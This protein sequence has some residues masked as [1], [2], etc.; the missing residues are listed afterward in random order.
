M[1]RRRSWRPRWLSVPGLTGFLLALLLVGA[2]PGSASEPPLARLLSPAMGDELAVGSM[3]TVEW[4]PAAGLAAMERAEEWEAF[5]SVDGG[6]TYP[7]R[8]TPHLD[9][10]IRR[11]SFRVPDLPSRQARLLLRFGDERREEVDCETR[12][13]FAIHRPPGYVPL[14]SPKIAFTRGEAARA[15]DAGVVAWVEG[16]RDGSGLREVVSVADPGASL[17]SARPAGPLLLPL[18]WPAPVRAALAPP[19]V[20]PAGSYPEGRAIPEP[21]PAPA[22][23]S[24]PVR[25]L[26]HRFNE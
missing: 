19:A 20:A 14:H 12:Q 23:A 17:E 15:G 10:S 24:A 5:L 22:G 9:L 1:P 18:L 16:A 25:L 6:A 7:L 21:S 2:V 8:I 3:A 11:F 26:I 13:I 4:E